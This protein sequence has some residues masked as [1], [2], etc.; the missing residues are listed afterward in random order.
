MKSHH[1]A[2]AYSTAPPVHNIPTTNPAA[3]IA[4]ALAFASPVAFG[5]APALLEDD[6]IVAPMLPATMAGLAPPPV[7]MPVVGDELGEV[8]DEVED[9][10][11]EE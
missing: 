1:L 11:A 3:P 7:A 5:A 8:G 9:T 6:V 4:Q 10:L 2:P